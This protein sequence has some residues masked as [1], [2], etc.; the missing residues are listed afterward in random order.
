[1]R[2]SRDST[3]KLEIQAQTHLVHIVYH[4]V[5][6]LPFK[7]FEYYGTISCNELGLTTPAEYH[8]LSNIQY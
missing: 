8:S 5:Y 4:A 3:T 1:M 6:H 2:C 7:R